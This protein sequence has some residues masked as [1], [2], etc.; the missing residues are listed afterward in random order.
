MMP[1]SQSALIIGAGLAGLACALDLQ[2]AGWQ[3]T[4]LE[5]RGRVGGRVYT[6]REGFQGGLYAEGGGEFIEDFHERMHALTREYGLALD[7]VGGMSGWTEWVALDGKSGPSKDAAL[8][9]LDLSQATDQIWKALGEL[10]RQVPD[11]ARPQAAPEAAALDRRSAADWLAGLDVHPLAKTVFAARLRSEYTIEPEAYSLLDLARWGAFYYSDVDRER[12]AYRIRGGNDLLPKAMAAALS[13]VRLNSPVTSLRLGAQGVEA[14]TPDGVLTAEFAVL[15]IPFGPAR[16]IAFD[17]PLPAETQTLMA[18][19]TYGQVTKVL[20]Q[21]GRKLS[22]LGW[23]GRVITD[24]PITCTWHPTERQTGPGD[25]VTVY[26]GGDP[27][28]RFSALPDAERIQAAIEQVE[29]ICPGSAQWVTAAQTVAWPNERYTQGSYAA[30]GLGQVT[31]LWERLRQPIGRLH[32]AGEHTA[33]HQ[34]YMEG[35]VES[36]QRAARELIDRDRR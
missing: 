16:Q 20:I 14:A 30:F 21:Y 18:G 5:A 13:D 12:R 25:I 36:G 35:A 11:P 10:G 27:G 23:S 31:A 7:P 28:V 4:V 6:V 15:A 17:P 22:D 34:G 26:T 1:P 19:L 24:L 2:R 3:V 9:G 8:W 29:R 33:V 32:L